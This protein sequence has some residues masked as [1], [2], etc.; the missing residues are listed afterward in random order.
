MKE[1]KDGSYVKV[2]DETTLKYKLFQDPQTKNNLLTNFER[3]SIIFSSLKWN[4][5]A[6]P[7]NVNVVYHFKI[8]QC[9]SPYW[10]AIRIN[11]E[12][13]CEKFKCHM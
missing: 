6:E 4:S 13:A 12:K 2:Q 10:T 5:R 7:R 3:I 8:K 1:I 11:I 9:N